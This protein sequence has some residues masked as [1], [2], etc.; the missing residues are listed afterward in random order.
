MIM[1]EITIKSQQEYDA[2]PKSFDEYTRIIIDCGEKW[3]RHSV[4]RE[5]SHVEARENSHVIAWGN[6]HVIAWGNVA[7]WLYSDTATV[8]LFVF[9]VCWK[10]AKGKVIKKSKHAT[11]I[12]PKFKPIFSE[13]QQ[14]YPVEKKGKKVLLYKAVHKKDGRYFSD[15]TKDFEYSIGEVKEH[16]CA[17]KEDSSCATGLHIAHRS[18]AYSFGFSWSDRALLECEVDPKDIVVSADCD[19]KVR[20]KR[21][22]V[23]RE[24][25]YEPE[26]LKD[27]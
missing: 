7:V 4:A 21:L 18:W 6:S 15:N 5:N 12:E 10:L 14:L 26:Y 22:K 27:K 16:E 1:K 19:G 13:Y 9:S 17:P 8:L 24:V 2:L 11:I 25:E 3:V 23:L 20:T